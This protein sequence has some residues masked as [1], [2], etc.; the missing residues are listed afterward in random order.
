LTG[1]GEL[2]SSGL[3]IGV[4][5]GKFLRLRMMEREGLAKALREFFQGNP[6]GLRGVR[7]FKTELIRGE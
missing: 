3:E 2:L 7:M 1:K 4:L 6:E 5:D